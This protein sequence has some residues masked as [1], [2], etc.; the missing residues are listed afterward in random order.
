MC[1]FGIVMALHE[2]NQS[3]KGQIVDLSMVEGSA[4]LG[5]WMYKSQN[6]PGLW[7]GPRGTNL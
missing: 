2:R 5:S 7:T 3:N 6:V 4:Y 1:A